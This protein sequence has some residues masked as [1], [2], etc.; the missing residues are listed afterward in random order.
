MWVVCGVGGMWCGWC[1]VRAAC[2][3]WRGWCV[4]SAACGMGRVWC[5]QGCGVCSMTEDALLCDRLGCRA[6]GKE[7]V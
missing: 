7:C 3:V 2:G 6:M 5:G 1:V 4:V